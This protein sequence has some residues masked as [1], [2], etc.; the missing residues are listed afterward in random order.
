VVSLRGSINI[1]IHY[2][3]KPAER[4]TEV[5]REV[6]LKTFGIFRLLEP[7]VARA[8]RKESQRILQRMKTYLEN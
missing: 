1:Q 5:T 3:L 2:F 7:L 8:V 6:R 4:Q